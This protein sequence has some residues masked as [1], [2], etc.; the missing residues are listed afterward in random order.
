MT[1]YMIAIAY[2]SFD[3]AKRSI[4]SVPPNN[5]HAGDLM[6]F[7]SNQEY[8][9]EWMDTLTKDTQFFKMSYKANL[10]HTTPEGK[11]TNYGMLCKFLL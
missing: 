1:D 9:S 7:Y 5:L 3:W 4:D 11:D 6:A 8:D 10:S 2:D